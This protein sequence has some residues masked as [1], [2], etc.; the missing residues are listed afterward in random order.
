MLANH[1]Y[2][3]FLLRW[4]AIASY[5][6]DRTDNDIKNHWNTHLK[7]KLKKFPNGSGAEDEDPTSINGYSISR[8]QWETRLQTDDIKTAKQALQDALSIDNT[9]T[10]TT[11]LDDHEPVTPPKPC[12]YASSTENIARLLKE[13]VKTDQESKSSSTCYSDHNSP[14][15]TSAL[16]MN[17]EYSTCSTTTGEASFESL[18]GGFAQSSNIS[19]DSTSPTIVLGETADGLGPL[20]A[21]EDWLLHDQ[22]KDDYYYLTNFTFDHEDPNLF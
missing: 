16:M 7:K 13:W 15:S 20:S 3:Y 18:F 19:D 12:A 4:A 21:L 1:I 8:G 14:N 17:M 6:P 9:T 5:L 11:T 10:T 22:G 2:I